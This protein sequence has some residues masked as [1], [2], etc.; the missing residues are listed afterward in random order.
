[1]KP[2]SENLEDERRHGARPKS[3]IQPILVSVMSVNHME[4]R[5]SELGYELKLFAMLS[6]VCLDIL[7]IRSFEYFFVVVCIVKSKQSDSIW[8]ALRNKM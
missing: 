1:M 7:F 6:F 5:K 2:F 8:S 3:D 4:S